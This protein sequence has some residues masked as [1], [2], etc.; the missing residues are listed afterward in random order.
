MK[1]ALALAGLLCL[2]LNSVQLAAQ[3]DDWYNKHD[4]N[5]DNHWDY[6]EFRNAHHDWARN[7]KKER[8]VSDSQLR[9]QFNNWDTD[10]H[11]YVTRE[12]VATYHNW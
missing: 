8:R 3:A 1:K 2:T 10:H 9:N 12:H 4:R 5:H 6:N 11:G 7:H